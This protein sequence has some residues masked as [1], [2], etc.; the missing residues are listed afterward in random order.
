MNHPD[1]Y[2]A[3]RYDTVGRSKLFTDIVYRENRENGEELWKLLREEERSI[4]PEAPQLKVF[5]GEMHGHTCFSDGQPDIDTYFKNIRDLAKLDFAAITDHDHGG[6]GS[7]TLW[8]GTPSKWDLTKDAVRRYYDKGNFTTLLAY[9]RDSYP[10]Y[11][12]MVLYYDS[13][14]GEIFRG[15]RDG[16]ICEDELKALKGRMDI[17]F[18]PHDSYSFTAGCDFDTISP[19]LFPPLF[20][21]MSRG[22]AAEYMGNPAFEEW[23]ACEGGFFQ[24]ALRRGAIIGVI[25]GS[26]DHSGTN[27]RVTEEGYPFMYP[28]VTG[29]WASEN[30][31][32]AIFEALAARRTYGF[33]LGRPEGEMQGRIE[34]DFRI[35]SHY[36]GECISRENGELKIYFNV[37]SD[38]PVKNITIVKNCRDIMVF[39]YNRECVFDYRQENEIDNFYLRVELQDGRF[40]WTSPIYVGEVY[41]VK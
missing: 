15:K 7:P 3:K 38:V 12:N 16:E 30:S 24:D 13:D 29:V 23:W 21:I 39:R 4:D 36:M 5:Y 10:F 31:R 11:N 32:E 14:C 28:G 19:D 27:G 41:K 22:D 18:A 17:L 25:A 35:N 26:D 2:N 33:M 37:R 6:V 40:G 34:I 8:A 1:K 20:E 9:E